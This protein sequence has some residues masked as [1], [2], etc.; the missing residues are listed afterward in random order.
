MKDHNPTLGDSMGFNFSLTYEA[1][2][3]SL[4]SA[5]LDET[6]FLYLRELVIRRADGR[7]ISGAYFSACPP[8]PVME[9]V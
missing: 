8:S 1:W 4:P 7:L 3:N 9:K 5:T 2:K 6:Q